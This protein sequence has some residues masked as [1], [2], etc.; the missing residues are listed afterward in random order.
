MVEKNTEEGFGSRTI[1]QELEALARERIQEFVGDLLEEEITAL[2]GRRKSQRRV[3]VDGPAVYRNGYG[4]PRKLAMMS[5]TIEVCRPRVRGLEERFESQILPLFRRR[6]EQVGELL[7]QLYL[8]GLAQGDFELA[9]RGLLGEAAPLSESSI[10]RLRGKWVAEFEA[11]RRRSL[12]GIEPVYLWADGIYVKAGLEKDKACLLVIVACLR[13]GR[14]AV[15]AV[16]SGYRE[17][18][19]SWGRLL[20]D[21]L[22]RGMSA[23]RLV[24]ADGSMGIWSAIAEVLPAVAEQRCW[25]HK[26]INVLDTLPKK[27]HAEA[28]QLLCRIPYAP[29][30]RAAE[31][32]REDFRLRYG[33]QQPKAVETLQRDWERLVAFYAFPKG[34][35]RHLRTTNPVESPFATVRLRTTAGKRYKKVA[36]ATALI[37]RVLMVA[38]RTFR[39]LHHPELL[40][41]VAE[42]AT[43][44]DGVRM[45]RGTKNSVIEEAAA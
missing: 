25:N 35:W 6:T 4:K 28:R 15:L 10:E 8:H 23:P 36:N 3:T 34:H 32:L 30:R 38:E 7:P 2:I 5:G 11:W 16:E 13:D 42:G 39:R 45:P 19:E 27:L 44:E 22:A 9:L 43:Y 40:P 33:Q 17:S 41:E 31:R 12:K 18:A 20:R 29:T 24:V 1:W 14:K 26:I 37:W 21:L